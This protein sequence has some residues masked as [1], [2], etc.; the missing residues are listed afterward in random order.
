MKKL[1]KRFKTIKEFKEINKQIDLY[2]QKRALKENEL[3]TKSEELDFKR[4][5]VEKI[6]QALEEI[7]T[8]CK[9]KQE[10]LDVLIKERNESITKLKDKKLKMENKL[11]PKIVNMFNRIYENKD[12]AAIVPVENSICDGC[13]TKIPKQIEISLKEKEKVIFCP[14]CSRILYIEE[15]E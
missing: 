3:M 4:A 10:E 14:F 13:Y 7:K 11:D 2:S 5:K 12:Q 8:N 15:M 1:R 9:A 6:S